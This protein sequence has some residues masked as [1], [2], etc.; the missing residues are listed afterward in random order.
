MFNEPKI[1]VIIYDEMIVVQNKKGKQKKFPR[2]GITRVEQF[3][4]D[5]EKKGELD[6]LM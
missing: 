2:C 5:M 6:D 4:Y 3:I 1:T